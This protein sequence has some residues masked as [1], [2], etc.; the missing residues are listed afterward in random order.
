MIKNFL[1]TTLRSFLKNRTYVLI[2]LIGLALSLAVCIVAYLNYDYGVSFDSQHKNI[3]RIYKIQVQKETDRGYVDYGM[4]PLAL[5]KAIENQRSEVALSS[6]YNSMSLVVKRDEV[7]YNEWISFVDDDYFSMFSFPFKY[8]TAE[9]ISDRK[10]IILS[11]ETAEKY[12]D[13]ANPLGELITMIDNKGVTRSYKVGGVLKEIPQ[14]SSMS[15]SA[16]MHFDNYLS[17][18]EIQN[19]NWDYFIAAT[20]IMTHDKTFPQAIPNW[21]NDQFIE[22]Q[23]NALENWKVDRYYL[24]PFERYGEIAENLRAQWLSQPPP[25]P[26]IVVPMIMA[27]LMLLIACFNFTNTALATSS[28]RLKEIGIRKVLGGNRR[29]LI[30]QFMGENILLSLIALFMAFLI[31]IYLVPAYSAMWDFIDLQLD[32]MAQ[33]G[34]F[35]FLFGLLVMTSIVAGVYPS[36]YVSSFRPVSILRGTIKIGGVS[37]L[38]QVLL[39]GQFSLTILALISSYAFVQN[40]RFQETL[41]VGF[42]KEDIL[43]IRVYNDGQYESLKNRLADQPYIIEVAGTGNHIGAWE[44]SRTLQHA[45]G[46]VDAGMLNLSPAYM[47]MM[48]VEIIEGRQFNKEMEEYDK[49]HSI[50]VNEA[51][52]KEIGWDHATD[53]YLQMDDSVR[54]KVIGVMKDLHMW[55]FWDPVEPMAFRPVYNNNHNFVVVKSA[56]GKVREAKDKIEQIWYEIEPNKPYN[57]SLQDEYLDETLLVNKNISTMFTVIGALALI[58]SLIGLYTLVSLS[59]LKRVKEIGIRKVLGAKVSQIVHLVNIP[60]YWTFSVAA[61]LGSLMAWFAIDALMGSVFAYYQNV[62][63]LT[64]LIPIMVISM[65]AFGIAIY[66]IVTAAIQNPVHSLRY[67]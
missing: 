63:A 14:N 43:A 30:I 35:L 33:P 9:T 20:F 39:G 65:T 50:I 19:S 62:S 11:E 4:S 17:L 37:R 16:I 56:Q 66:R 53:R 60:Y 67:E 6:R 32:P 31:S 61:G 8:G 13:D 28:K 18:N 15:F 42:E 23:N 51:L 21:L 58:L 5:G 54:L 59:V 2:N 40:A 10:T 3:N 12:F 45:D 52:V 36:L 41:D 27:I 24:Q 44:Y 26:A 34:L 7:I 55:G 49:S 25:K 38:S 57:A 46:T 1:T 29:Q 47:T 64:M 22:V 48:G